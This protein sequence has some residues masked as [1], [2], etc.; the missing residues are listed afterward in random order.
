MILRRECR[1]HPLAGRLARSDGVL[2]GRGG[3]A[4]CLRAVVFTLAAAGLAGCTIL[5]AIL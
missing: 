5:D 2:R 3:N 4:P 1:E